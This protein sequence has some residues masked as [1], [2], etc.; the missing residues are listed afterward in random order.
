MKIILLFSCIITLLTSSGCIIAEDGR[1]GRWHH[2]RHEEVHAVVVGPPV[3]IV[4]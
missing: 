1:R 2:E 4:H 3:I